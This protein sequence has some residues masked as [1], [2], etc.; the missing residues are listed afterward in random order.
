MSDL[1]TGGIAVVVVTHD[2]GV[3]AAMERRVALA[4]GAVQGD[5][6]R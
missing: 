4:D 6:R 5:A 2:P 1:A 3:A